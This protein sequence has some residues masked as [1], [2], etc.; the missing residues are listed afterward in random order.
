MI[1]RVCLFLLACCVSA[2]AS[3]VPPSRISF[4]F[5]GQTHTIPAD[6]CSYFEN[7]WRT[8]HNLPSL[9][10]QCSIVAGGHQY[11][12]AGYN[13]GAHAYQL[14]LDMICA[15]GETDQGMSV[16]A[17]DRCLSSTPPG[18]DPPCKPGPFGN[19]SFVSAY[20]D[21]P[22]NEGK[23]IKKFVPD[24][25]FSPGGLGYGVCVQGCYVNIGNV[26]SCA[27]GEAGPNGVYRVTCQAEGFKSGATCTVGAG[28]DPNPPVPP[29][30]PKDDK[31]PAGTVS[32]GIDKNGTTICVG[33]GQSDTPK[34]P[35]VTT[36][37][38]PVVTQNSDGST[39]TTT[40]KTTTNTDGSTTT[41][42]TSTTVAADGTKTTTSGSTTG[43]IPPGP[44]GGGGGQ[45]KSDD[46]TSEFCKKNP[47]LSVCKNSTVNGKCRE[48]ACEGDAIQCATLRAAAAMQCTQDDDKK[49]FEES[50][51]Y[52]LGKA[53]ATGEDPQLKDL[54]TAKNGKTVDM[55]TSLDS[56]GW[57]GG[58]API[59][60]KN[61]SVMGRT[62]TIPF[63]DVMPYLLVLRYG[64]FI[65]ALLAS[66]KILSGAILRE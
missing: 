56:A 10:A 20:T 42:T 43:A 59:S 18:T 17:N 61:F 60:N 64:M 16:A 5:A 39:T 41:H 23:V 15:P 54:P 4:G 55:P 37:K 9:T 63:S 33:S 58:G 6:A 57:I 21:G 12:I 48:T 47:Q 27:T 62:F 50:A 30:P 46:E 34:P 36:E 7:Y 40:T 26:T 51:G 13:G 32:G 45:G 19:I 24:G 29:L 52:K 14:T 31:C 38:P 2:W 35:N 1:S 53:V 3:A 28:N 65:C 8:T 25:A 44:N 49:F 11:S 66:F 22:G